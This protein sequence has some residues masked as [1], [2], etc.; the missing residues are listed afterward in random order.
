MR[1]LVASVASY[2]LAKTLYAAQET[3]KFLGASA[4]LVN[5]KNPPG[6][7]PEAKTPP[8][9]SGEL[10]F[11]TK[12]TAEKFGDPAAVAFIACDEYLSKA[13]DVAFNLVSKPKGFLPY[14]KN[15]PGQVATQL[16]LVGAAVGPQ[17]SLYTQ[18]A[19]N[20]R[21]IFVLVRNNPEQLGIPKT[22]EFDLSVFMDRAYAVGDFEAIW[23][24]EGL[25]HVYSQ[26]TW[27]LKHNVSEDAHGILVDGQAANM[28]AKSLTMMHAGLGL[29]VAES[30]MKQLTVDSSIQEVQRVLKAFIKICNNNS[31]PGYV[32]CALESLGLV[33]RCFN[34]PMVN[35]VQKILAD[36]DPMAWEFF[37]R[38]AGRALY[39]SPGHM[40]QPLYSPWIAA[41][42]E[43]PNDRALKILKAGITWPTNIVNMRHPEII[44][45][46]VK[47]VGKDEEESGAF[48]NGV[49]ASTAMAM[50]ITPNHPLVQQY[51]EYKPKSSDPEVQRLWHKLVHEPAYRAKHRYQP[52]LSKHGMMD[53]VFRFQD[54]DALVDRLESADAHKEGKDK[55]NTAEARA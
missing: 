52:I 14:W 39:F 2:G 22:G 6:P 32:G 43:A 24:V 37:W 40:M 41:E 54:L 42:Q 53:Q 44:E 49:A 23:T 30:L 36:I 16:G 34:Y 25:G 7:G 11:R 55:K 4:S 28:P 50:D 29:A 45:D 26:R 1:E 5:A 33:T 46:L 18:Q 27:I 47:R 17:S 20:T 13:V 12:K 15:L 9:M 31:R 8:T 51:I 10:Y 35:L 19:K 38:G 3:A 48:R 21:Y